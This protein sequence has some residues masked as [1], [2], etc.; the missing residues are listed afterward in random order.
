MARRSDHTREELKE[1]I[2]ETS[3]NVVS[4]DG[5][6]GLSARRVA[7]EIG[8]T[9]G[10]IY[11]LFSSMDDLYLQVSARTL[12]HLHG[13][14]SGSVCNDPKK[15][16]IQ[17]MRAMASLYI[18]FTQESRKHW[19]MLFQ[20]TMPEGFDVPEWFEDK[21]EG[22]FTPLERQMQG[23]FSSEDTARKKMAARM[24]WSSVHGLC[25]LQETGK[26]GIVRQG[27]SMEDVAH[28]L[29]DIFIKGIEKP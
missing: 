29:I 23:Y 20:H 12:T 10:T 21:I 19:L 4:V 18:R 1:L 9:P 7:N 24:L 8:Y 22:M 3:W 14:L 11:N 6:E 16:A 17:N 27:A 25:F 2:L 5:F 13:L 28:G 15:T 26:I